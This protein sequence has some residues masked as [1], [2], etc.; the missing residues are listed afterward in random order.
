MSPNMDESPI[1]PS[2][3]KPGFIVMDYVYTPEN[4][5]L[6][7]EARSRGCQY[8][9]AWIFSCVRRALQFELFNDKKDPVRI[10]VSDRQTS[11][12]AVVAAG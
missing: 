4:T 2:L 8:S 9:P 3:M 5:I 1:H 7:K 6:I 11:F 12:V 10:D